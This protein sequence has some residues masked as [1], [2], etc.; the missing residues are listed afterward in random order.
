MNRIEPA[1]HNAAYRR[2][3]PSIRRVSRK[4]LAQRTFRRVVGMVQGNDQLHEFVEGF[5]ARYALNST[6]AAAGPPHRDR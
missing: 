4:P 1:G 5:I 3:S 6:P 2:G